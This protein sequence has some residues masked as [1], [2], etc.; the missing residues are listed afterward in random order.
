MSIGR[1]YLAKKDGQWLMV[2]LVDIVALLDNIYRGAQHA[3]VG[4][5]DASRTLDAITHE[6]NKK[7]FIDPS[8]VE[9][10][11]WSCNLMDEQGKFWHPRGLSFE[12]FLKKLVPFRA[13]CRKYNILGPRKAKPKRGRKK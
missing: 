1:G 12:Q 10:A 4:F 7:V 6:L 9:S 5:E 2:S 8:V 11:L 13:F 3:E